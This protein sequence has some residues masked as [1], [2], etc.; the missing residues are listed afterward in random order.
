[1][2][3]RHTGEQ[4]VAMLR[5][6]DVALGS[7]EKVPKVCKELESPLGSSPLRNSSVFQRG[8]SKRREPNGVAKCS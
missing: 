2:K 1:M 8:R 7:W 3:K 4:I 6:A 5:Q